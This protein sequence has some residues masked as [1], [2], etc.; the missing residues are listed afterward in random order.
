[1]SISLKNVS[2]DYDTQTEV[3]KNVSVKIQTGEFFVIVGP[4][5]C[6]KSTLLRMIAGLTSITDGEILIN[7]Q[8]INYLSPKERKLTMVFQSY[9]LYPFLSIWDNVAFGLKAR[10]LDRSD[11]KKRVTDALKMVNLTDLADRKPR[12][13]SGGQRQR[14]A[15]ARAIASDANICLMDEPL[16][17]LDAHLRIK[18]RQEIYN[19]Q[20]KLGLTLIYV[21]H[22]QVEAMTMADHIMVLH[23]THVEQIGTP[24]EI[25]QYPA[26]EF[27]AQFFGTPQIN[28][29][30]AD[31]AP[32]DKHL[33][34]VASGDLEIMLEQ[35]IPESIKKIGI[36]PNDLNVARASK[37]DSNAVVTNTE[38]L[39]N[40]TIVYLNLNSGNTIRSVLPGQVI[41]KSYEPVKVSI[42]SNLLFFNNQGQRI[43][44]IKKEAVHA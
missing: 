30:P 20:R 6:G 28:I 29:L 13:I 23:D 42:N 41:F 10:K 17:N 9:A 4:S 12:E 32:M 11:I 27:V 2:K 8:V 34:K 26:N 33:L 44:L 5:G 7:D 39:G 43:N 36:R 1:M 35:S 22:D 25:Y 15:L 38:F 14:V 21:T 16:S 31:K 40:Q 19:L 24:A 37:L 18:M 3:L